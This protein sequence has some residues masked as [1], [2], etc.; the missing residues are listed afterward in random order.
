MIGRRFDPLSLAV[1]ADDAG[2]IEVRLAGMQG[3]DL[4]RPESGGDYEFKH[5]DRKSVV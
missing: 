5:A 1:V 2:E 3:L 4:V